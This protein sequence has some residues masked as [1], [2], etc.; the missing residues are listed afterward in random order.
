MS[1]AACRQYG[2]QSQTELILCLFTRRALQAL[3]SPKSAKR[4]AIPLQNLYRLLEMRRYSAWFDGE[5]RNW[6]R[7]IRPLIERLVPDIA[8]IDRLER[9]LRSLDINR[10]PGPEAEQ[11]LRAFLDGII[12]GLDKGEF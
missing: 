4:L 1:L 12:C 5:P 2:T 7:R 9:S 11:E 6:E 3:D 8:M 10:S